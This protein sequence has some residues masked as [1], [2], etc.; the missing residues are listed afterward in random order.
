[1]QNSW[2]RSEVLNKPFSE[3]PFVNDWQSSCMVPLRF[4]TDI[5]KHVTTCPGILNARNSVP[6]GNLLLLWVFTQDSLAFYRLICVSDLTFVACILLFKINTGWFLCTI[7][8]MPFA[9]QNWPDW[10]LS[11]AERADTLQESGLPTWI[12]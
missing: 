9:I 4:Y 3:F 1:M 10:Y 12:L 6:S 5:T 7:K 11:S 2:W 8:W